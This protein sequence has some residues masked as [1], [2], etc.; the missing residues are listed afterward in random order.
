M[1]EG[2]IL[3]QRTLYVELT[4]SHGALKNQ[5][6]ILLLAVK[7]GYSRPETAASVGVP[8]SHTR[9]ILEHKSGYMC[10]NL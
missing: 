2:R 9:K 10:P 1:P 8:R 7:F 3:W 4:G 5:K 6:T